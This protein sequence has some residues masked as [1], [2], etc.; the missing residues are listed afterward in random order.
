M[1]IEVI[2]HIEKELSKILFNDKN[3]FEEFINICETYSE[4]PF[5][6]L[7][8]LKKYD[9][10]KLKG[11]IFEHFCYK[12]LNICCNLP[13]V[14]LYKD[15]PIEEKKKLNLT[16]ND[17]GIDLIAQDKD[18][19]YY[20]IQ[21]KYRKRVKG[22]KCCISW[23][24]LSTFYAQ[25]LK[26]GPFVKHIVITNADYITHIGKKTEKDKTVAYKSLYNITNDQWKKIAGLDQ[27]KYSLNNF[28]GDSV[29]KSMTN[30][31]LRNKR[32]NYLFKK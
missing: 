7:S 26:S 27:V 23:K 22:R 12:Y 8:E 5:H 19:N 3:I 6:S 17:Y 9:R 18:S 10:K 14:W 15:F 31:E 25:V 13:N 32:L 28:S 21:A 16:K 2:D 1:N 4:Q 20:A 24:Q 30:E 11:D 29:Y